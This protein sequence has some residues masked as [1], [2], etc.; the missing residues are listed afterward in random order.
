MEQT[1]SLAKQL[2]N[3]S[4]AYPH[5]TALKLTEADSFS[6]NHATHTITYSLGDAFAGAYLLHEFAHAVLDHKDFDYDI[7]LLELER[8]AWDRAVTLAPLY[9]VSIDTATVEES[10][11]TYRDWLHTRSLCPSCDSTGLQS[12][13]HDYQCAACGQVWSVNPARTCGLKRYKKTTPR[14]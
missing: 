11:D 1:T 9:G 5:L 7:Q 14:R 10:L 6:W 13:V 3:D 8:A 12:D 2:K 4:S